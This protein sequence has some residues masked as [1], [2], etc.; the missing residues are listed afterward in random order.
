MILAWASPFNE[1][2][3]VQSPPCPGRTPADQR[4][5]QSCFRDQRGSGS[6]E[7]DRNT[8]LVTW[9]GAR[10]KQWWHR[11]LQYSI[12]VF[13]WAVLQGVREERGGRRRHKDSY[14]GCVVSR[15][16]FEFVELGW[17]TPHV[18]EGWKQCNH[19]LYKLIILFS[20]LKYCIKYS[21]LSAREPSLYVRT[22]DV[23]FWRIK[24]INALKELGYKCYNG[25]RP[26]M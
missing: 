10:R 25:R 21:T 24:S 26:I 9:A 1:E 13:Q 14:S 22:L 20:I 23:R 4:E 15:T 11:E 12:H 18:C 2:V 3:C 8:L 16:S 6:A 19:N 7:D 17:Y 5:K